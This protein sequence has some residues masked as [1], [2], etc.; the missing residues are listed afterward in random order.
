MKFTRKNKE[1]IF[2]FVLKF[3]KDGDEL[4]LHFNA[5]VPFCTKLAGIR[6]RIG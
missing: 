6:F 4:F 3:D 2:H 5:D 1:T